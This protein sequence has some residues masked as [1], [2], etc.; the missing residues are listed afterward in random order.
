MFAYTAILEMNPCPF[1]KG[2]AN[3]VSKKHCLWHISLHFKEEKAISLV[4]H[5]S[6]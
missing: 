2:T 5:L 3:L 6:P 4:L 1:A